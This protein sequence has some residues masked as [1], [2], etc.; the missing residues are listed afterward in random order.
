MKNTD[1]LPVVLGILMFAN[2]CSAEKTDTSTLPDTSQSTYRPGKQALAGT[3]W[4]LGFALAGLGIAALTPNDTGMEEGFE[5]IAY[6]ALGHMIGS[7]AGVHWYGRQTQMQAS[8]FATFSGAVIGLAIGAAFSNGLENP[9]LMLAGPPV[10]ATV[11]YNLTKHRRS[12]EI[13][14]HFLKQD[15]LTRHQKSEFCSLFG[16][17]EERLIKMNILTCAL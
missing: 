5:A 10:F 6:S 9:I 14:I 8:G 16:V 17:K 2:I 3:L 13:S 11:G 12:P 1:F 15:Q 7:I 4:G